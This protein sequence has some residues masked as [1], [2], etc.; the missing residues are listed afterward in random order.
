MVHVFRARTHVR[1]A[2]FVNFRVSGSVTC[3]YCNSGKLG[4]LPVHFT[5]AA[6]SVMGALLRTSE[7][8]AGDRLLVI[9][10]TA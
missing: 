10:C 7:T 3:A 6:D 4:G 9:V 5:C 1:L 8:A 2:A